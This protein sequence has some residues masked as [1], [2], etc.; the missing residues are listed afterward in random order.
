[1]KKNLL[2]IVFATFS[3][4]AFGQKVWN[5]GGE[6][7]IANPFP[8]SAGVGMGPFPVFIDGLAIT[9][10]TSN[11]NMGA[12]NASAKTFTDAN[13]KVYSFVNRF[14]F[15]GGGYSGSTAGDTQP[16]PE[17]QNMP[18]QRF[19]SFNVSGNSTIYMIG[20]TGSSS[21][22]R[23]MF[24]TD[25]TNLI[26]SVDFPASTSLN[27]GKVEYTGPAATLYVFGNAAINLSLL[28][29][30]NFVATSV[31]TIDAKKTVVNEKCYDILGREIKTNSRGLVIRKLTYSDGTT[32][33]VK[34]YIRMER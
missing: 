1:M 11:V 9:G 18:T 31:N 24:V 23:K 10:T 34:D 8:L 4:I 15:N 32:E 26:G 7:T 25:G 33:T 13:N 29:A 28:S 14:Q 16:M 21:S 3:M 20:V 27:D 2:I 22:A 19:V 12:V 17:G 6:P 5:L 30:T